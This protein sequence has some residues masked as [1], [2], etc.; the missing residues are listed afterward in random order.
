[1]V[2]DKLVT[3][4]ELRVD[5]ADWEG[6]TS[7]AIYDLFEVGDV[8]SNYLLAVDK[9]KGNAGNRYSHTINLKGIGNFYIFSFA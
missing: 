4:C 9:Y 7:Y 1:L 3:D 5:M 8:V 6:N 2:I